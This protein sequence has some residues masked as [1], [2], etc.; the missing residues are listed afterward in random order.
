MASLLCEA[1]VNLLPAT[2]VTAFD[3]GD[4]SATNFQAAALEALQVAVNWYAAQQ[5]ELA[6]LQAANGH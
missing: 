4:A 1:N 2:F 3:L 6:S 5:A